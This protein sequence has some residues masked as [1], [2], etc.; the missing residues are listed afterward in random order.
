MASASEPDLPV[1]FFPVDTMSY[2]GKR[3]IALMLGI[4]KFMNV[5]SIWTTYVIYK[6]FSKPD[7][8]YH[9]EKQQ[10]PT[11][12]TKMLDFLTSQYPQN[13][14]LSI[15]LRSSKKQQIPKP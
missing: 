11:N 15:I 7:S 12:L 9:I 1:L 6:V 13:P 5:L 14:I 8:Q 10:K 4:L 3:V 2:C